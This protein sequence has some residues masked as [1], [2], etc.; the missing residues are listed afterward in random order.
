MNKKLLTIA[1]ASMLFAGMNN[2]FCQE[3]AV[4]EEGESARMEMRMLRRGRHHGRDMQNMQG[5]ADELGLT[6]EQKQRAEEIRQADVEKMKPLMEQMEELRKQMDQIREENKNAFEEI[7]TPEQKEKFD[8]MGH[9]GRGFKK[10]GDR[11]RR[12]HRR[13]EAPRPIEDTESADD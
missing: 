8:N 7:L 11:G 2:A 4:S 9:R 3:A 5:L 12:H 13:G 1:C 6:E 10:G